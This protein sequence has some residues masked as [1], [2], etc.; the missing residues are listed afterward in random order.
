MKKLVTV[1]IFALSMVLALTLTGCDDDFFNDTI[2]SSTNT[3]ADKEVDA[4]SV[5]IFIYM[6]GSDLESEGGCATDDILEMCKSNFG[7]NVKVIIQ[8]GGTKKWNNNAMTSSKVERFQVKDG[9]VK[10]LGTVG[11]CKD[12]SMVKADTLSKFLSWGMKNYRSDRNGVILWNHGGGSLVGFGADEYHPDNMLSIAGIRKGF[13]NSGAHF[14]FVGFDA[15]MMGTIE[16]AY[17][18]HDYA[19]YMIASEE[20]EPGTGWDYRN[21][22]A[23]LSADPG[24]SMKDLSKLIINDFVNGEDGFWLD[25]LTLALYDLKDTEKAYKELS[26]YLEESRYVIRNDGFDDISYARLKTRGYGD[27]GFEQIDIRTY[28]ERDGIEGDQL[29]AIL[30]DMIVYYKGNISDSTGMAMYYPYM[31]LS[32]Y[33]DMNTVLDKI[34]MKNEGHRGYLDDF[35]SFL[36]KGQSMDRSVHAKLSAVSQL[37]GEDEPKDDADEE[38]NYEEEEWYDE[39]AADS[40]YSP[41]ALFKTDENLTFTE[42]EDGY[43]LDL[44]DEQWQSIA[45]VEMELYIADKKGYSFYGTDSR[46]SYDKNNDLIADFDLNW[47]CLNGQFVPF[48]IISDRTD[49]RGNEATG[50]I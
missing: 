12:V 5:S 30:E 4:D 45:K 19:D 47:V 1:L 33:S 49:E 40:G 29:S 36:A 48:Y 20:T 22:L 26:K 25:D 41:D 7:K 15:C 17:A 42:T 38:E 37:T 27:D 28:M 44:T 6:I 11:K 35:V 21:W 32:Y 16:T 46:V 39:D 2:E 13:K 31:Y 34:G 23:E 43:V 50:Y 8:T 24:M 14:D 3:R 9:K 18:L 10:N